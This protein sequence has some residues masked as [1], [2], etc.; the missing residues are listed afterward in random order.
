[1]RFIDLQAAFDDALRITRF[2][3]RLQAAMIAATK[4]LE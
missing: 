1:M 2:C 3:A 4:T